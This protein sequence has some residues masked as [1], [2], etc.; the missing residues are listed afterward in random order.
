MT[1]PRPRHRAR[2]QFF[3]TPDL[4]DLL[5]AFGDNPHPSTGPLPPTITTLSEILEDFLTETCHL[6]SLS[7]SYSRRQKIKVDDFKFVLRED[8]AL[9]GR[10]LEQLWKDRGLKEERRLM[11]VEKVGGG[12]AGGAAGGAGAGMEELGAL[13]EMGG[14]GGEA[15]KK[16]KGRGRGGGRKR[17]VDVVGDEG[18][19]EA[20]K[21]VK[22]EQ[23]S[24]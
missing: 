1:E 5:Y 18:G 11:D 23:G 10:A 3:A 13:A 14:V 22:G 24:P 15:K 8:E 17:K 16:G 9:L 20:K 21:K 2:G 19:G 7:A 4:I 6:A 12:G